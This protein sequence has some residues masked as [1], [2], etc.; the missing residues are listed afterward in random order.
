MLFLYL[1]FNNLKVAIAFLILANLIFKI[2]YCLWRTIIFLLIRHFCFFRLTQNAICFL[3]FILQKYKPL[4]Y[5]LYIILAFNTYTP[6]YAQSTTSTKPKD[7]APFNQ[8]SYE[9]VIATALTFLQ[10]RILEE[11]TIKELSLWGLNGLNAVDPSLSIHEIEDKLVLQQSQKILANYPLPADNDIP[12]WAKTITDISTKGWEN[13][14]LIQLANN[15]G[16]TQ[17]FFDELFDHMD[18][19][20]R[21]VA[22]NFASTD[23]NQRGD[24][25]A[26]IGI[27]ISKDKNYIV[28]SSINT[29]GPAWSAGLNVGERIY[30]IDSKRTYKQSVDTINNWLKGSNNSSLTLVLGSHGRKK[31]R[32]VH[33]K[34]EIVPPATVFAFTND[35]IIILKITSFSTFT[36]EEINQYLDQAVQDMKLKG[37]I[38]DLRGNRGGVLQQAITSSALLLDH[39]IAAT[40]QGRDQESNHVWAVQ[41]GD[42]TN[43]VPIVIL[44]DGR[45]ASAAEILT[46]ALSD[47]KRAV[48]IGSTTL[49][50]GLVQTIAQL[51]DG[52]ELFVTWSR[53]IAPLGWPIQSLGIIPQICTSRGV[54]F[55]QKQMNELINDQSSYARDVIFSRQ[56]RFPVEA[57]DILQ[58]RNA[59]PPAIGSDIDLEI[60]DDLLLNPKLYQKALDM[61]PND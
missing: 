54:K 31:T 3:Y 27:T 9:N 51:P 12:Q 30:K 5:C 22:P 42:I 2:F 44:V 21:Y 33:L 16:L 48:V 61:I 29:N 23:R 24:G 35:N 49:G 14:N 36:A 43:N 15:Q 8:H 50:K 18:P 28:I 32:I 10:P 38:L 55:T 19:Y 37:L 6:I 7:I 40:T 13:S 60:A 58:I 25:E 26:N 34:R 11:H 45:T 4:F 47:H 20:S 52:G 59:C 53:V 1:G 39:G 56:S 17:A 46:A 57:K 41:G